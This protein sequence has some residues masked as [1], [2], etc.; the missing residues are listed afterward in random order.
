MACKIEDNT[1]WAKPQEN[2]TL[3]TDDSQKALHN[4]DDIIT[5]NRDITQ[6]MPVELS[7]HILKLDSIVQTGMDTLATANLSVLASLS[8]GTIV[9]DRK[10]DSA[11]TPVIIY[12]A[13]LFRS[14]GGKTVAIGSN[15]HYFLDWRE[16]LLG[17]IQEENDRRKEEIEIALKSLGSSKQEMD[18]RSK[19]ESELLELK[20]QPDV[21]LEDATAEGFEASIACNS[22]PLLFIDNFGK[23]L[24]GA[25]KSEHKANMIRMMD[26][27]FD[28]GTTTTRRLKGEG[29]RAKQ[30]SIGGFGAH[31][32]STVGDSNL[33][34][35][36]I[37]AN[38]QN[39]FLNKVLITFQDTIDKPIPLR[40]SLSNEEK[41]Q[42]EA[43]SKSY[44]NMASDHHFYLSDEAYEV[45]TVFHKHTSD[46]FIRRYNNDEDLAGLV[47]RL[48][49]IAKRI[50]CIFEIAS[51]CERYE[52]IGTT[53]EDRPKIPISAENMQRAID[54]LEYLKREHI[55]KI[56]LYAQS[57]NGKLSTSEIVLHAIMRLSDNGKKINRRSIIGRLSK[58]HRISAKDLKPIMEQLVD[59]RKI[60]GSNDD[61]YSLLD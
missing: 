49:K 20:T 1:R 6:Y 2:Q 22:T 59:E 19:L 47:I 36:D 10:S 61:G 12:S 31:F 38:I 28:S 9:Y 27:V 44:F 51:Q 45:Y 39:G 37:K 3:V 21:Y 50:A 56:M 23:Y 30:L 5:E 17:G 43:F 41:G 14:G 11:G 55:S 16:E 7:R 46:E 60:E 33:K 15:R 34:P 25:G 54:F 40:S 52:A 13:A 57:N 4:N 26:N 58:S 42:I 24:T 29:K 48:L 32:A 18:Q 53:D 35:K 8:G